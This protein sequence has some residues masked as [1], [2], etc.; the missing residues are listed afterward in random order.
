ME[1]IK[2]GLFSVAAIFFLTFL[3]F[4][5][6]TKSALKTVALFAF[7]GVT[8]LLILYFLKPIIGIELALNPVTIG[9]SATLG[10]AGIVGILIAPMFF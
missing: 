8:V 4:A 7:C 2:W 3:I 10:L 9:I 5:R 6:K 1:I